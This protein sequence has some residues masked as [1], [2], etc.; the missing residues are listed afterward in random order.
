MNAALEGRDEIFF[1]AALILPTTLRVS[2]YSNIAT[3]ELRLEKTAHHGAGF[4]ATLPS[5]AEAHLSVS[6][7]HFLQLNLP[8][9]THND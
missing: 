6:P 1:G 9:G 2:I 3:R 4:E 5:R 7:L 8:I